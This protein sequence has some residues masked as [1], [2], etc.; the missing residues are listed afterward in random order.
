MTRRRVRLFRLLGCLLSTLAVLGGSEVLIRLLGRGN[1]L[2]PPP[3][4]RID[5]YLGNPFILETRPF[6]YVGIPGARYTMYHDSSYSAGYRINERGFRGGPMP[7]RGQRPRLVVVGDSMVEGVG[8]GEGE[9]FAAILGVETRW[10]VLDCGVMGAGPSYYA[11]NLPRYLALHPDAILLALTDNDGTDD[12]HYES[13]HFRAVPPAVRPAWLSGGGAWD[14]VRCSVLL[15]R[16]MI[17]WRQWHAPFPSTPAELLLDRNARDGAPELVGTPGVPRYLVPG[18][19]FAAHWGLSRRYLDLFADE[20]AKRHVLVAVTVLS[21]YNL[22]PDALPE[23]K[24]RTLLFH[25]AVREWAASRGLP[26]H[27]LA[28]VIAAALASCPDRVAFRGD[29]HYS[30]EGHL[31]VAGE[32]AGWVDGLF[33]GDT[34]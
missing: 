7:D 3:P 16:V 4:G 26:F 17:K 34:P 15:Q 32:L 5:P 9:T 24:A 6:L 8:V 18:N 29:G 30:A 14:P 13:A 2:R 12:R 11:A 1:V 20:C 28:G 19:T 10:D 33:A 31:L 23:T 27:G 22:R 25:D 21:S